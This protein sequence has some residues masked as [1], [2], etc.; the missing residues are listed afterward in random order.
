MII[1]SVNSENINLFSQILIESAKWLEARDETM[2]K[3]N[4]LTPDELL[5]RYSINDMRICFE[6]ESPVGVFVLQWY[7]P[8]FWADLNKYDSGILHKL[9]ISNKYRGKGYGKKVIEYAEEICKNNNVKS[10]R[11][12]CG[13][14]RPRLRDFYEEAG[15]KM[16]DRVFM[17]NKDQIRY[18]KEIKP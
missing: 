3:E 17:D 15:F 6:D 9:A 8:L 2:W 4:D 10:L 13:T 12:N 18:I 11:L 7:D 16:V 14:H 5:K 1:N